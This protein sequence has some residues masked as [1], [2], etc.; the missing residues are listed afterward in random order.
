MKIALDA[1]NKIGFVYWTL[2]RPDTSD[3]TFRIW[4]RCDS[5]VKSWLLN[6]VSPRI[7]RSILRLT[8][9]ADIWRDSMVVFTSP[10]T[11]SLTQEIQDLKQGSMFLSDYYTTLKML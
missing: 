7:Y 2:T 9:A 10:R 4:S 11:F 5:M 3:P 8:D 1:K 6:F